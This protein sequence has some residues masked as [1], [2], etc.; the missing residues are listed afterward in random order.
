MDLQIQGKYAVQVI[1][2]VEIQ[3]LPIT[4]AVFNEKKSLLPNTKKNLLF[5]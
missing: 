4:T 3:E 1:P 2:E 5:S